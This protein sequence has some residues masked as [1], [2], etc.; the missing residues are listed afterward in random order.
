MRY[1]KFSVPSVMSQ[2][3]IN[4]TR[5]LKCIEHEHSAGMILIEKDVDLVSSLSWPAAYTCS[6]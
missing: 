5:V 1:I 6:E 2:G 4:Q 3:V